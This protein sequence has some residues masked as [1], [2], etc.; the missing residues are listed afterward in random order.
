[1]KTTPPPVSTAAR[2]DILGRRQ[3]RDATA[4][5]GTGHLEHSMASPR[6][7]ARAETVMTSQNSITQWLEQLR[8]GDP[9]AVEPLWRRF[10][11]ALVRHAR[12][13]LGSTPRRAYD[14]EDAAT[15]AFESFCAAMD[16]GRFPDLQ[17]RDGL[18]RLLLTIT[19]RKAV[20]YMEREC[21]QKRGGGHVRGESAVGER[22]DHSGDGGFDGLPALGEPSPE[23]AVIL[24]EELARLLTKLNDPVL[25][26]V[27][28]RKMKGHTNAEIAE[29]TGRSL[30]TVERRL[31]LI[32]QIWNDGEAV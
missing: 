30:A 25:Q 3:N 16:A 2:D 18:W 24:R 12:R 15:S 32:R 26:Q 17:D 1:L 28:T 11:T 27:A 8:E 13:K 23:F 4:V 29:E 7:E 14:E 22:D 5:A 6:S 9:N 19:E 21:R 31:R 10:Y 20:D